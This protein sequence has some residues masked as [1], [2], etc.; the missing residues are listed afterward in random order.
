MEVTR[1]ATERW[2]R[3]PCNLCVSRPVARNW[4]ISDSSWRPAA[5]PPSTAVKA[6]GPAL[7]LGAR[8]WPGSTAPPSCKAVD[9]EAD[10][11]RPRFPAAAAGGAPDDRGAPEEEAAPEA[12]SACPPELGGPAKPSRQRC[13]I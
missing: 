1:Q 3:R 11:S 6:N 5:E 2:R 4:S 12:P 9:W 7:P 8:A 13:R 10:D